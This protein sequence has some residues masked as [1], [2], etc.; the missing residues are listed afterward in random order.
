MAKR[1]AWTLG[2]A[3]AQESAARDEHEAAWRAGCLWYV[4]RPGF[5]AVLASASRKICECSARDDY[6]VYSQAE[7]AAMLEASGLTPAG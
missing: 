4:A 6:R 1:K 7:Y 3:I 5:Y 2:H